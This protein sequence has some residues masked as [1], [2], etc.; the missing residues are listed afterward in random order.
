MPYQPGFNSFQMPAYGQNLYQSQ[1]QAQPMMQNARQEITKVS[2][3]NGAE[4]YQ[5][6]AN[7]SVLL[8]D[9]TAPIVWLKTT[10]GAGYP[11]LTPYSITPYEPEKP[12]DIKSLEERIE[13][14]EE[15]LHGT[16]PDT[17]DVK[18]KPVNASESRKN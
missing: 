12:A 14:L 9:E 15:E 5:M 16:E 10:D 1:F 13:K 6:A 7:S 4:M 17:V 3:R 8:L 2:G 18:R 11:T